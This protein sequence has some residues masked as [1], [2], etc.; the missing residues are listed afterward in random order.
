MDKL[1]Q[2]LDRVCRSI[3]G[4]RSLRQHVRQELREHLLDAAAQYRSAGLSEEA[5]LDRALADF[6]GPEEVREEL[7]ATHGH[8]LMAVV[9]D[10]AMQWQERTMKAKWLWTTWAYLA[11]AA[12]VVLE[13]LLITFNVIFI[14]PKF[15]RLMQYG[16][17]DPAIIQEQGVSWMPGFLN[18]L[19][20]VG[21]HYTT[22]LL[23]AAVAA[24]GLFEWRVRG[25][26]K[27]FIR[28]SALGTAA[29][30]LMVVVMLMAGALVISF[31]LGV[32]AV[33]RIA[34]P[35]ALQQTA[36]IDTSVG[37][38][39]Q[40][41]AAKNWDAM[42]AEA[43]RAAGAVSRLEGAAPAVPALAGW[44]EPPTPEDLRAHLK[45]ADES[46]AEAQ[47]AI[48]AKDAE[49]LKAALQ[50]F[51]EQYGPVAQAAARPQP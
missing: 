38:L 47:R 22:F 15:Q 9:I 14:I 41:L 3:G 37:A 49:R 18:G 29:V 12:V 4:P 25:E 5:A 39:E 48:Q 51:R 46:L 20:Y 50:K 2:Y 28:L 26:N 34:R 19:S 24:V 1:E 13:V 33:G 7:E 17:I 31:T 36:T 42:Q 6:G 11:L 27:P 30:G 45:A 10:K 35:F 44:G 32:P 8:R 16:I 21:G 23:L 43:T 40:A